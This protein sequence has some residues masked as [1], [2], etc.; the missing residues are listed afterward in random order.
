MGE[1]TRDR[2]KT[3]PEPLGEVAT[4]PLDQHGIVSASNVAHSSDGRNTL[5]YW[6]HDRPKALHRNIFMK[7]NSFEN[8]GESALPCGQLAILD[9]YCVDIQH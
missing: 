2:A 9:G 6:E 4:E 7:M 8:I 1:R 3:T 5:R